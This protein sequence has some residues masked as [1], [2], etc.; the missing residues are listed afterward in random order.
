MSAEGPRCANCQH[1]LPNSD[2]KA[3]PPRIHES[4]GKGFGSCRRYP[5]QADPVQRLIDSIDDLRYRGRNEDPAEPVQINEIGG[6]LLQS[7]CIQ[8]EREYSAAA[9]WPRVHETNACGEF[10]ESN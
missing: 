7:V 6:T 10:S 2:G 4:D 5:P 1:Y 3:D 9:V 8:L